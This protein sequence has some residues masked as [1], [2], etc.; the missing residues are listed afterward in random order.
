M[1]LAT[2]GNFALLQMM[3]YPLAFNFLYPV[4]V[5]DTSEVAIELASMEVFPSEAVQFESFDE[6]GEDSLNPRLA[7]LGYEN[8]NFSTNAGTSLLLFNF[9]MLMIGLY[10]LLKP[11]KDRCCQRAK[12]PNKIRDKIKKTI[13]WSGFIDF[14]HGAHIDLLLASMV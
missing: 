9:M 6:E 5:S 3:L 8:A 2:L 7:I 14:F 13:L 1:S 12:W 4:N 10:L 11:C